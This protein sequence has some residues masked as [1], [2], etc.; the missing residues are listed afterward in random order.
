M[1]LNTIEIV[2][3]FLF[4][5]RGCTM[6]VT[7]VG[8]ALRFLSFK[9]GGATK[10]VTAKSWFY[11]LC[12]LLLS[13]PLKMYQYFSYI[14]WNRGWW[15]KQWELSRPQCR[16]FWDPPMQQNGIFETTFTRSSHLVTPYTTIL[17]IFHTLHAWLSCTLT[18]GVA[19]FLIFWTPHKFDIIAALMPTCRGGG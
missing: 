12:A 6:F 18:W 17:A 4:Y 10:F 2:L 13:P 19:V 15:M 16:P 7:R 1:C 11:T 9:L 5:F 14:T 8:G 3:T